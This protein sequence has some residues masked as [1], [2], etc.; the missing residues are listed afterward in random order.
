MEL[1]QL[2]QHGRLHHRHG[3]GAG[4]GQGIAGA[5]GQREAQDVRV[6]LARGVVAV[7]GGSSA[8]RDGHGGGRRG[9]QRVDQRLAAVVGGLEAVAGLREIDGHEAQRAAA[10]QRLEQRALM[11]E[12]AGE[13][14]AAARARIGVGAEGIGQGVADCPAHRPRAGSFAPR[15]PASPDGAA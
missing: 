15:R 6:G 2:P 14:S 1:G 13:A 7:R 12:R 9:D 11:V 5:G 8:K 10:G 4:K 3:D